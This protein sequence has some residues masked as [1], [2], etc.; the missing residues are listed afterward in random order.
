MT[1]DLVLK[2]GRI[3]TSS[4]I[5][6]G[7]IAV[8]EGR[9]VGVSKEPHLPRADRM[10]DVSGL[11]VLPGFIDAHVHICDP[12]FVLESFETGTKAAAVGGVTTVVDMASSAG[13]RTSSV[14]MFN[15]K[16]EIAERESFVDF[17]LFGGEIADERDLFEVEGLVEAGVVGFGEIMMCGDMPVRDDGVLLEAFRLI[18][19]AGSVAAVHAEDNSLLCRCRERLI[20]EGRKDV[21]AFADARP[22]EAESRAISKVVDFG[23]RVGVRLHV[24]HL[25][26]R[27]GVGLVREAKGRGLCVTSEVC[28]HHLFLTRDCYGELG[29][30]VVTTPPLRS[31]G[32]VE[33]L[34][35]G[36]SDG[37]VD[38]VVSD[39]CAFPKREKDVG[40]RDVWRTPPGVPGL[41]TLGLLMLGRGVR[42]GRVSLERF[43]GVSSE[44]PARVF[45]LYPRKGFLGVG[46]DADFVV[47]DL[48]REH[49]I[50]VGDLRC[51]A[52]YTPFEGWVVGASVVMTLVR[53]EVVAREGE[54]VGRMGYGQFVRPC[55]V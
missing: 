42:E 44:G 50:G 10:V 11:F 12:G 34:W 45:G 7:G 31:S 36:L 29:P 27:E 33:A 1:V 53:G 43:V 13:M 3:A 35:G 28:P 23:R 4:G 55:G 6:E 8:D 24:C 41:E 52:D 5:I 38:L 2:R 9:I 14:A 25:S 17:G 20:A 32:D 15:R 51:V 21:V 48:G 39:H 22:G 46:G 54:V 49:R 26:T 18:S 19:R 40:W 47:V 30:Y 16:R 37:T